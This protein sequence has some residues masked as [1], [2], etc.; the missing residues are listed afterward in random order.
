M[1]NVLLVS[2]FASRQGC[3][4]AEWVDDKVDAFVKRGKKVT[5]ISTITAKKIRS[6]N[7]KHI[8]IPSFS[9]S[10]FKEERAEAIHNNDFSKLNYL[11]IP[12]ICVLG[13]VIDL[14]QKVLLKGIGGG[15]WSWAPSCLLATLYTLLIGDYR[16]IVTTGGPASAHLAGLFAGKISL[17]PIVSELQDPLVGESIG[18]NS[19]SVQMQILLEKLMVRWCSKVVFVTKAAAEES[20]NRNENKGNI[21]AIYPGSRKF[22]TVKNNI[23]DKKVFLHLGTLYSTRNLDT[24]LLSLDELINEEKID[25]ESIEVINLGDIYLDNKQEYL[26]RS[27]FNSLSL[28]PRQEAV[29]FAANADVNILVQHS[30]NRS[31]TTIPYKT[32]DY[33]NVG[34]PILGLLNSDE[35]SRLLKDNGH[36]VSNVNNVIEIKDMILRILDNCSA[37]VGEGI[38]IEEQVMELINF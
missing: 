7:V 21:V 25:P 18:R 36:C 26:N 2:Y 3:C 30:D 22:N 19:R 6:H 38:N 28:V 33:L 1:D 15:R 20:R 17:K 14:L 34:K 16:F 29:G 35:L 24:F 10:D 32:Y 5:L 13:L 27:Y 37:T 12:F 8:R 31:N 23:S 4:P 9:L 11:W